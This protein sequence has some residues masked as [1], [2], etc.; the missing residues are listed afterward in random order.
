MKQFADGLFI[1]NDDNGK[2]CHIGDNIK[3]I[4]EEGNMYEEGGGYAGGYAGGYLPEDEYIGILV[5]LKSKGVAIRLWNGN[6]I[7]PRLTNKSIR[8]WKWERLEV[9]KDNT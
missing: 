5:L 3:V 1:K 2:P 4:V 6:Y 8:K 7:F 9:K